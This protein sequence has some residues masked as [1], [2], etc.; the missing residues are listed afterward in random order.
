MQNRYRKKKELGMKNMEQKEG[1]ENRRLNFTL[2]GGKRG[3]NIRIG[4]REK[5]QAMIS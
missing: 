3:D 4:S 2:F 5:L 1:I